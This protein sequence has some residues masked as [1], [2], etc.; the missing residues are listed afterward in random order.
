MSVEAAEEE[1]IQDLDHDKEKGGYSNITNIPELS[2][3]ERTISKLSTV[4]SI[5]NPGPPPDGGLHAW[6]QC[7][8]AHLTVV[9]IWGVVNSYGL[10]QT[11]YVNTLGHSPSDISWIGSF[12][13]FLIFFI[14]TFSGRALDA[15]LFRITF[16][17]GLALQIIGVFTT[18]VA[19]EY[20]QIFLAQGICTG[21]GQGLQFC[22]TIGLVS[23]YFSSKKSTALALAAAGTATG[24]MIFPAMIQQL[25]PKIGFG[26]S[27]RTAGFLQLA[28]GLFCLAFLRSRLPPRVAGPLVEWPAFKEPTYV[29]Y[30]LGMFFNFWG[31][32]FGFYY[33][34]FL[35]I[36]RLHH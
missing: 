9:N 31:V 33:V 11:Y 35:V 23:T 18:S 12:Q 21:I 6:F 16:A 10:F 13:I 14:G 22:P 24:G 7:F 30:C 28:I 36:R 27:L 2:P 26:W 1:Y 5:T 15:G 3:L 34:S 29:L 17:V 19:T 20:W 25:L 4:S 8:L 32:Y